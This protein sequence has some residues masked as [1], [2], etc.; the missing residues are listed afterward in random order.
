MSDHRELAHGGAV[1][2]AARRHGIPEDQW[3]DLSTGI[4]PHGWP[5]PPLDPELWRRLP[6]PDD[7]LAEAGRAW[8]GAPAASACLPVPGTQAAIQHLPVLRNPATV[9]VPEPG[10]NEHARWWRAA[11]H[12]VV[13]VDANGVEDQLDTLDVLVWIHPNN[14]TGQQ[15]PRSVLR[16]WQ[17][18][19]ARRGGWLVVDEAFLDDPA[20]SMAAFTGEDGL[21]VLQSLGKIFGLA[22]ART[23]L[24]FGPTTLCE[25]LEAS[26]GPWSVPGPTRA[27]M[28]HALCDRNWQQRNREQLRRDSGR[29]KTLLEEQGLT[30]AGH[31]VLFAWCPTPQAPTIAEALGRRG[32]LVRVFDDPPALRIGLPG[33]EMQW[34]RLGQA[35][36]ELM[37]GVDN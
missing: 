13:T 32:I 6:E 25:R 30:V 11:G 2:A 16:D 10:Y 17:Q 36:T 3:L 33:D 37:A 14:P 35:L 20:E 9:G 19:L 5:V 23:G 15:L 18:R 28:L 12:E 4:N 26:L 24:I 34:H 8:A 7:G 31:T 22:G 29:L 27:V 1:R 21:I